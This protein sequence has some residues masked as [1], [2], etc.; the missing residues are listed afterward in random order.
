MRIASTPRVGTTFDIYLPVC[1][2][3]ERKA[4]I[5]TTI[6]PGNGESIAVVDDEKSVAAFVGARLEQLKY[7]A[8]VFNDPREAL[9]ALRAAP[10]RF[11]LVV[12]DLTMPHLT[13]HDLVHALRAAGQTI[14]AVLMSGFCSEGLTEDGIAALGQTI[15]LPKPFN[16][17]D[18]ARAVRQALA[19]GQPAEASS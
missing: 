8:I 9:A 3:A 6:V 19:S 10:Q 1:G 18:L 7:R 5:V 12:T 14:P 17:D 11:D 15:L 13:G 16:G 2:E 4:E